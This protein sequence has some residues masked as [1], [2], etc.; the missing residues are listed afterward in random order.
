MRIIPVVKTVGIARIFGSGQPYLYF[1]ASYS[2]CRPLRNGQY[3]QMLNGVLNST[4]S[5]SKE[6]LRYIISFL[7][8]LGGI[9]CHDCCCATLLDSICT[10][11]H[12][13][14]EGS[15]SSNCCACCTCCCT[16]G[17]LLSVH[18]CVC[19]RCVCVYVVCMRVCTCVCTRLC[20]VSS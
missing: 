16:C 11:T 6:Q 20:Q 10:T 14:R 5:C 7:H 13:T 8:I 9:S 17:V 18:V 1:I 3:G 15:G 19:V 2:L 4:S 12:L